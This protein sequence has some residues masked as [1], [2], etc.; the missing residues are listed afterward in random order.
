MGLRRSQ[1]SDPMSAQNYA[2]H[3][4]YVPMFHVVLF[5]ILVFTLIGS[6]VN[7]YI[8]LGDHQRLYSA[9]FIII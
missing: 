1:K 7:L 3:R 8:S 4:Q 2:N 6:I 9:S 5:G